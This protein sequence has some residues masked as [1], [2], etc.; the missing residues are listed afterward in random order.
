MKDMKK[1]DITIDWGWVRD[2]VIRSEKIPAGKIKSSL[3]SCLKKAGELARPKYLVVEKDIISNKD[4]HIKLKGNIEISSPTVSSHLK[5]A[6]SLA[7]FLV[8]IGKGVEDEASSLM[9]KADELSG[10]LLD[11]TGSFAVESLA[12]SLENSLRNSCIARGLTLSVRFSPGYCDWKI[13]EQFKLSRIADFSKAGITLTDNCMMVPR[14]S[15]SSVAGIGPKGLFSE[16]KSQCD[17][18]NL[19][20]CSYR[21]DI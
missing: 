3:E 21:R 17:M 12:Q 13:E 14:K 2:N 6:V 19:P 20:D 18:C 10:Y 5:G 1:S 7:V 4:G 11:R 15:I 9:K 8:T 16:I